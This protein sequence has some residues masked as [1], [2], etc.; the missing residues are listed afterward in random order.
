M[1]DCPMCRGA[2]ADDELERIQVWDDAYWR[3]TVSLSSEVAGFAYLE[4]KRHIP[5][6]TELDGEEAETFGAAMATSTRVLKQVTGA[7]GFNDLGI[8]YPNFPGIGNS[9]YD[10]IWEFFFRIDAPT[11]TITI[12]DGDMD[13]GSANCASR[14]TDDP[15]TVGIPPFADAVGARPEGVA[16]VDLYPFKGI[17]HLSGGIILNYNEGRLAAHL[18]VTLD[19]RTYSESEVSA[20]GATVSFDRTAPYLGIGIA[21]RSRIAFVLDLGVG[22]TGTPLVDLQAESELTGAARDELDARVQ[23]EEELV[24]DEI[25]QRSWLRY[26]PVLS[27]GLK[28]EF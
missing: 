26:H 20:L 25:N 12:W 24:R 4:P 21:G 8:I 17:F 2:A 23:R 14:D 28:L 19:G 16:T 18:P 1:R 13:F 3:L 27:V 11:P 6:I 10:G 7:S 9:T 22:F 5:F 15:D